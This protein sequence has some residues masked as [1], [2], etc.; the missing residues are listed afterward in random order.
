MR[1][2]A[3]NSV[4]IANGCNKL[5]L[6]HHADDLIETFLLSLFYEG[7]LSTFQPVTELSRTGITVIRPL[8][9]LDEK[10]IS[11]FMRDKPILKNPC[12]ADK[13]TQRQYVKELIK[14]VQ[15]DIPFVKERML[16]AI[17][18]PERNNLFASRDIIKK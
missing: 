12:P 11:S 8:I 9:Y 6:G 3:L 13:H 1:R 14:N 4:A 15:T 18:H 16:G 7:R 10:N 2:G 5:S 17:T